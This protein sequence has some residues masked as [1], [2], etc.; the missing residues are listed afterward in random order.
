MADP[1]VVSLDVATAADAALLANLLELYAYDLSE[2]FPD[3][4]LGP[5]GR[6]GYSKLSLYWSEPER[7]FAF[8]IRLGGRVAG[9]ALAVR[10]SPAADDPEVLDVAE[11]FVL[12]RYRRAGVGRRAALLLWD[13]LP[14]KWTV[15]VVERNPAGL[16]FWRATIAEAA[17]ATVT[18]TTRPAL[19]QTWRVFSFECGVRCSD[20]GG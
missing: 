12:R 15:R 4:E 10:G 16:A 3:V 19:A 8:L 5:N 11:F 20:G 9:F 6:F 14:G 18:E 2:A 13:R 17:D 1:Q 7:R